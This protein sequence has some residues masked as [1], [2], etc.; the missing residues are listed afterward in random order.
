MV[1]KVDASAL[2]FSVVAEVQTFVPELILVGSFAR[3]YW[4][5]YV[6]GL[7]I[8]ALTLDVDVT[9][10][11]KSMDEYRERLSPL[12]GPT[13]VGLAFHVQGQLVDIIP[14]GDAAQNGI[15]EPVPGVTLD[16]TGMA[17]AAH[18]AITVTSGSQE[19]RLPTLASLIALKLVAWGYRGGTTDKDA[20]DLGPLLDA[21]YLGPFADE[22]WAD[23]EAG[24][25]W[26][27]DDTLMGP[28]RAG[29]EVH[30]TW[31]AE[32][33]ERLRSC[34][35]GERQETLAVR[36]VRSGGG[37]FEQRV[38]QLD[39]FGQGLADAIAARVFR[40]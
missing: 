1:R 29:V 11:V 24:K 38:E 25:R 15:I 9:I 14:Y 22:V 28:Y 8:G 33:L 5:H 31:H 12:D 3:D 21:T 13:G 26:H 37:T 40:A 4:V 6:A 23:D 32:S 35:A 10:L 7:P 16:V 34:L 17:E 27:Y 39:A 19:I 18:H 20:R 30:D 2:P 36:M